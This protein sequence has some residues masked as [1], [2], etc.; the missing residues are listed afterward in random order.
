MVRTQTP[1]KSEI[2]GAFGFAGLSYTVTA[3]PS[4]LDEPRLPE[5]FAQALLTLVPCA[6]ERDGL[7]YVILTHNQADVQLVVALHFGDRF[8]VFIELF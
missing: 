4:Q 2:L 6:R 8:A 7:R 1:P 5:A 3:A